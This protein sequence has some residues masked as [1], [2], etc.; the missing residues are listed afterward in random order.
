MYTSFDPLAQRYPS[1]RLHRRVH[2]ALIKVQQHIQ[3]CCSWN[4]FA[5]RINDCGAK[6]QMQSFGGKSTVGWIMKSDD[7]SLSRWA[8][9]GARFAL[10]GASPSAILF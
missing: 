6:I 4:R 2:L 8:P 7:S 3:N 10:Q 1:Q 5:Y 9:E